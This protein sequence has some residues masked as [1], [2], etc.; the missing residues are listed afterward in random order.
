MSS[1]H[2][3]NSALQIIYHLA[4]HVSNA[5]VLR[6]KNGIP[7]RKVTILLLGTSATGNAVC[8]LKLSVFPTG[9]MHAFTSYI[10]TV[11]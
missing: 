6:L 7:N 4:N 9:N 3:T 10:Y 5:I 2:K 8:K 1:I 11:F